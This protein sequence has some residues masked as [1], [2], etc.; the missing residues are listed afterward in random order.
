MWNNCFISVH[1]SSFSYSLWNWFNLSHTVS[2]ICRPSDQ[3]LILNTM[4]YFHEITYI[5]HGSWVNVASVSGLVLFEPYCYL[6]GFASVLVSFII[7][8][9]IFSAATL[10]QRENEGDRT[11]I[12]ILIFEE[13]VYY[14]TYIYLVYC[15]IFQNQAGNPIGWWNAKTLLFIT[16]RWHYT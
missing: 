3:L 15:Y 1:L 8:I 11:I 16:S 14:N 2:Y 12:L 7:V 6:E 5:W 4:A 13:L 10:H 9:L